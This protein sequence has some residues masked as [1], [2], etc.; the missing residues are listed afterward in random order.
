VFPVRTLKI[1]P[2]EQ[3][4]Q[5]IGV[6]HK[7]FSLYCRVNFETVEN[8]EKEKLGRIFFHTLQKL[9]K[10]R[11]KLDQRLLDY[12][13]DVFQ[14][15]IID[16]TGSEKLLFNTL[17]ARIAY[18]G[19]QLKL[20]SEFLYELHLYR[21][22]VQNRQVFPQYLEV[23]QLGL[24]LIAR[25]IRENYGIPIPD[26]L[27]A[28][29][30]PPEYQRKEPRLHR[31]I[32]SMKGM[33]TG[34][35]ATE[36]VFRFIPGQQPDSQWLV[37]PLRLEL[38]QSTLTT[39]QAWDGE[40]QLPVTV[41]LREIGVDKGNYLYPK[42]IV[43]E[44]DYLVD[45]TAIAEC[46]A[47]NGARPEYYFFKKFI[48]AENS[49]YLLIGNIV[50]H[51]LDSLIHRPG[52]TFDELLRQLF[53]LAP[54]GFCLVDDK[55]LVEIIN[56]VK[57][58]FHNLVRVLDTDFPRLGL[59][60]GKCVVEPSF[61]APELG[62]QGRL[63]VL[64]Q[65]GPGQTSIIELKSG[66]P[67]RENRYGLSANHYTQT[68]LYD[69]MIRSVYSLR[70]KP[71]NYILYSK[72]P[73]QNLRFAPT[74]QAAQME[75]LS[76]RNEIYVLERML[77]D[78][79][80][81]D[82]LFRKIRLVNFP[83][84]FGFL[85]EEIERFEKIYSGMEE[86]VQLY[87]RKM[88]QF[89]AREHH[90]AKTGL[91][92]H[93]ENNGMAA[94]WLDEIGRKR[95][96]MA[97][98]THLIIDRNESMMDPPLI[99]LK[100]TGMSNELANFREGD[101]VV[102]RPM[103]EDQSERLSAQVIRAG[104][105]GLSAEGIVLKL[106][107]R[108][109]DQDFFN[110]YDSWR[111]EPDFLDSGFRKMY[112]SL[113]QF[114][115]APGG[116]QELLLGQRPPEKGKVHPLEIN[117]SLTENQRTTLA[118][119]LAAPEYFLLWG[120]PGTGKTSVI[121]AAAVE[122]LIRHTAQHIL[123]LAYTNR[124]VDEIC[125]MLESMEGQEF[126]YIRIG[127]RY[128]TGDRFRGKLLD[129]VLEKLDTRAQLKDK[130]AGTRIFVGT[131]SSIAGKEE[132]F[133]L[134]TFDAVFI[135]EASQILEP[136]IIG[137]LTQFTKFVLIGDHRQ[138]PAVVVQ[139]EDHAAIREK[140][141]LELGITDRRMAFFDRMYNRCME[142]GWTWATGQLYE[143]GRMHREIMQF[144]GKQF[145]NGELVTLPGMARLN[146]PEISFYK[147]QDEPDDPLVSNRMI[148]IHVEGDEDFELAKN[149]PDESGIVVRLIRRIEK[150]VS[151]PSLIA[152]GISLGVITPFRAQIAQIRRDLIAEGIDPDNYTIDTVERYQGGAKDIVIYSTVVNSVKRLD[153]IQAPDRYGVDRK[154]NVALTRAKE[155]FILIGNKTILD[156]NGL[157]KRLID[158]CEEISF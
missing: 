110:R 88:A 126:E 122:W 69:L 75:A 101:I 80:S 17:F 2:A 34:Y 43:L 121:L 94:L 106:R 151:G 26:E 125:E 68:L 5:G 59:D 124:A 147:L 89:I 7:N 103:L 20:P 145:Y 117:R 123:L 90:L 100:R 13:F 14:S 38:F 113:F 154:L 52:L 142:R 74:I 56:T 107:S 97:I 98:Y 11:E 55:E 32:H 130:L 146:D 50:N 23:Y 150:R 40:G 143:Q 153:Q 109:Y 158:Q 30:V 104:L 9:V 8:Q 105:I 84:A 131:T 139:A 127:S 21:K 1:S 19:I 49:K 140:P 12:Q 102:L 70:S 81:S 86:T 120:P 76:L 134:K 156:Q 135:D 108:Q 46:F 15:V 24:Y 31:F 137:L 54:L 157:Y 115:S 116:K 36:K 37:S 93:R 65:Q 57:E 66:S 58:H 29:L 72:L 83:G 144:P 35:D 61:Y 95:E 129:S 112:E 42:W 136:M 39:L 48:P 62:L 27:S 133:R 47:P 28:E 92:N 99:Y 4:F 138:L 41:M 51:V 60:V 111:L 148:F 141:L 78:Q 33:I 73:N 87:F 63:D 18:L 119:L 64:H 22:E 10:Q 44:P 71:L 91:V 3:A 6:I 128:A 132:L 96:R 53:K 82:G 79:P 67:F 114:A 16:L 85:R 45:V 118:K 155:Q 77:I 25:L 152:K 149:N